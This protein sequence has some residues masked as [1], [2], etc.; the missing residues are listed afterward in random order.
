[1]TLHALLAP[2]LLTTNSNL[3]PL[4]LYLLGK[5]WSQGLVRGGERGWCKD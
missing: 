2:A 1:M 4:I 3:L 5:V